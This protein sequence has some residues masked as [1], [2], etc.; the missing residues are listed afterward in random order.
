ML[1]TYPSTSE[2]K[3][4]PTSTADVSGSDGVAGVAP[5][6]QMLHGQVRGV[7]VTGIETAAPRLALSSVARA[8]MVAAP[9]VVGDQTYRQLLRPVAGC[10]VVPPSVETSTPPTLPPPRS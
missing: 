5:V 10:Q 7:T 1:V 4:R 8:R 2:R 6:P 3:R 9:A